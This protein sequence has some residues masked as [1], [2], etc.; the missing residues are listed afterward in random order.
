MKRFVACLFV[1]ILF[2]N[3]LTIS[4]RAAE[5][6]KEIVSFEDGS[7]AVIEVMTN[8]S[9]ASGSVTGTKNY[10]YYGT[11]NVSE[12][13]VILTGKFTYTGTS[14]NCSA[15]D[16]DI[17]VYDPIW[18]VSSEYTSK[19]GNKAKASVTMACNLDGATI[20]RVPVSLTLTCDADGNLS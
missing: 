1:V 16:V 8:G 5:V 9:R 6:T 15:S 20:T 19:S 12:W 2:A 11:D 10:T 7:Y 17:T 18:Y 13:K 14:A 3:L 4:G